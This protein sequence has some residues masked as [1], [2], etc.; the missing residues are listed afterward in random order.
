M[1]CVTAQQSQLIVKLVSYDFIFFFATLY[2]P[3]F[4]YILCGSVVLMVLIYYYSFETNAQSFKLYFL[5]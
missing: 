3:T 2:I 4:Y 5:T 1:Q